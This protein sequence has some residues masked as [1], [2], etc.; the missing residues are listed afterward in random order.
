MV[1]DDYQRCTQTS[2]NRCELSGE[3]ERARS[4]AVLETNSEWRSLNLAAKFYICAGWDGC[5]FPLFF[6]HA[7]AAAEMLKKFGLWKLCIIRAVHLLQ[8]ECYISFAN[9]V[10]E[11]DCDREKNDWNSE[12][13]E[14]IRGRWVFNPWAQWSLTGNSSWRVSEYFLWI[15]SRWFSR[16]MAR[17]P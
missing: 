10:T 15:K 1:P 8:R 3:N 16:R 7:K 11:L 17:G 12:R 14:N 2:V 6:L 5:L 13:K 9:A 4:P